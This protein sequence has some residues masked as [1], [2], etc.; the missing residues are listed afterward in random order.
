MNGEYKKLIKEIELNYN[1][2]KV[3]Q[4]FRENE[5]FISAHKN[6]LTALS[7]KNWRSAK[8]MNTE[9]NISSPTGKIIERYFVNIFVQY[10][11]KI[12]VTT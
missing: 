1:S 11:L 9:K 2:T 4:G 12:Q 8:Y 5:K 10:Y 7:D 6:L 3:F